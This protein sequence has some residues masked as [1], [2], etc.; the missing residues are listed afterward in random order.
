MLIL[1]FHF[2]TVQSAYDAQTGSVIQ[3]SWTIKNVNFTR[4]AA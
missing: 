1:G 2:Q 4:T 3:V